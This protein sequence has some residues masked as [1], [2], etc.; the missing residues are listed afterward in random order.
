M[1]PQKDRF[2]IVMRV[3]GPIPHSTLQ[4]WCQRLPF[5]TWKKLRRWWIVLCYKMSL[6]LYSF[7]VLLLSRYLSCVQSCLTE[8]TTKILLP[9]KQK[10]EFGVI[11]RIWVL[12]TK[13]LNRNFSL[14]GTDYTVKFTT[15]CSNLL[16]SW[17]PRVYL[18]DGG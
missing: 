1:A 8:Y 3:L 14:I 16:F 12:V 10:K 5:L 4:F 17:M 7:Y 13:K 18:S 2:A 9:V 6:S 15:Q 11:S